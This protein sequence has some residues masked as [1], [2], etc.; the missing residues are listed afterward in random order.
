[1]PKERT[2][3]TENEHGDEVHPAFGLISVPRIS[4]TPGEVLFQS[5]LRHH[6]YVRVEVHEASRKRDLKHDW[7]HPG[8]LVCEVSMSMAQ[9]ASFVASGGTVGVP[10]TIEWTGTG[11]YPP[12]DRPGLNPQPRL[13]LSHEE[14]RAA[15]NEAYEDIQK[16]LAAYQETLKLTGKGSAAAQRDALRAHNAT[17]ANAARNVAWA[18]KV[19]DEHAE[20]V[21]ELARADIEGIAQRTAERLG[22]PV[23]E[24]PAIES[25]RT[26]E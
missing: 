21:V 13:A 25:G 10:C 18:A 14:V 7:V 11:T 20:S 24:L 5:D 15:A 12:G 8:K 17:V 16:S 2:E 3:P 4:A 23:G 22:I 26:E 9:F 19:L 1:M 6:E